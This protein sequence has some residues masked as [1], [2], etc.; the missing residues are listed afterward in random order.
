MTVSTVLSLRIGLKDRK[1][2]DVAAWAANKS[3]TEFM[4]ESAWG[5][6]IDLLPGSN[7]FLLDTAEFRKFEK[8]LARAPKVDAILETLCKRPSPWAK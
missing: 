6:A 5:A 4:V 8:A 1:L 7:F 3:P 2:I